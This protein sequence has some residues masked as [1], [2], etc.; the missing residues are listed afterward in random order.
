MEANGTKSIT[1]E[2]SKSRPAEQHEFQAIL[3]P[4]PHFY[5]S[6]HLS[7]QDVSMLCP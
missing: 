7:L 3:V 2:A 6:I 4:E 5:Y 1:I